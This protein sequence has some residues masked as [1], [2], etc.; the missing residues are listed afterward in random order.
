MVER[1]R[2]TAIDG[3]SGADETERVELWIR[4]QLTLAGFT[5][6]DAT[7]VI[8]A[9]LDWR[10]LVRLRERGCPRQLALAIVR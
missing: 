8:A 4:E 7:V 1:L 6:A 9:G 2:A 3:G 10:A 5:D